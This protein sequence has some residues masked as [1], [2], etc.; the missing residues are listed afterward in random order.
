MA[1]SERKD[2]EISTS[3]SDSYSTTDNSKGG[4]DDPD[5][6]SNTIKLFHSRKPAT[7]WTNRSTN[8]INSNRQQGE[9]ISQYTSSNRVPSSKYKDDL[10][11]EKEKQVEDRVVANDIPF[12]QP[13]TNAAIREKRKPGTSGTYTYTDTALRDST[14]SDFDDSVVSAISTKFESIWV[15][16]PDQ[17]PSQPTQPINNDRSNDEVI[18][19]LEE[20]GGRFIIPSPKFNG[21]KT[22]DKDI[23]SSDLNYHQSST[24]IFTTTCSGDP[25]KFR[26]F[27][28]LKNEIYNPAMNG[29]GGERSSISS[30]AKDHEENNSAKSVNTT[31]NQREN[32]Y[33][34]N[35]QYSGRIVDEKERTK[36]DD[37]L[38]NF[39]EKE[40]LKKARQLID[41]KES[42]S[43]D[44]KATQRV[45]RRNRQ[46]R[47]QQQRQ[48]ILSDTIT[49]D[50][51]S[52]ENCGMNRVHPISLQERAHQAWKSRQNKNSS[53]R[54]SKQDSNNN[55]TSNQ[56]QKGANNVSFGPSN[57]IHRFEPDQLHDEKAELMSLDRSLNSEYTKTLESEVEDMIKDIFFIGTQDKS[58]PG[59]RKYRY[60]PGVKR[61]I[62]KDSKTAME[63]RIG[64]NDQLLGVLCETNV[65]STCSVEEDVLVPPLNEDDFA[66]LKRKEK[67]RS[68]PTDDKLAKS[69]IERTRASH[70]KKVQQQSRTMNFGD[71]SSIASS[72]GSSLD[73]S[74]TF[75]SFQLKDNPMEDPFNTMI[76]FVEGGLSAMTSAIGFAL[77]DS[78]NP[79]DEIK[80]RKTKQVD[81][82][83][84]SKCVDTSEYGFF[85]SCGIAIG[86]PKVVK[87][88]RTQV[89][90]GITDLI[91]KDL[92]LGSDIIQSISSN[93]LHNS[94]DNEECSDDLNERD[95]ERSISNKIIE[96]PKYCFH[97]DF[98]LLAIHACYSVHKLQG[99]EYD[100]S[101]AIDLHKEVEICPVSLELP[102]GIIFLEN[103]GGCFVTKVSPDGS[104]A[105]SL[106]VEMGDQL[107][108]INGANSMKMKV[109]DICDAISN[110]C[111]S[112][113]IELVFLRYIGPFRPA[114]KT[115][116][117]R[118]V[119]SSPVE[120]NGTLVHTN[121]KY[122]SLWKKNPM[123][124]KSGFRLFGKG[125]NN[126]LKNNAKGTKG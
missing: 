58:K 59:R 12:D 1:Y 64:R 32:D 13:N 57:I 97:S 54:S 71:E 62:S 53:L 16:S 31:Q 111:D 5:S 17:I 106:G 99:V 46:R 116:E 93:R 75:E 60:K 56:P 38:F 4:F 40:H 85:E 30:Y 14:L 84:E 26:S 79:K 105:R 76:G 63:T 29:E 47:K 70:L 112:S 37:S 66:L 109:D 34:N 90:A 18:D 23:I 100:D 11:V 39:A 19:D 55:V 124:I 49:D 7:V 121:R 89:A 103:D 80:G 115:L 41:S 33:E 45:R 114:N 119:D 73:D 126:N 87:E 107:A 120:T 24:P 101:V 95:N 96:E 20:L 65:E 83:G 81:P 94:D 43:Q 113:Q 52:T 27:P 50:D 36:D 68:S 86:S 122:Y 74:N 8:N 102:L 42:L 44:V 35:N 92:L 21:P 125:K 10:I 77:G 28:Q 69:S 118:R 110:S 123:K 98:Y 104:A 88:G 67:K 72:G 61:K 6:N 15:S 108:S 22:I 51:T 82:I 48:N 25:M 117:P 9:F 2:N 91:N 78:S 3:I